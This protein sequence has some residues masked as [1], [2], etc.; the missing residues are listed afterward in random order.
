MFR[1]LIIKDGIVENIINWS[2]DGDY[3]YPFPHDIIMKEPN[4]ISVGIGDVYISE[5]NEFQKPIESYFIGEE[6]ISEE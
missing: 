2:G 5:T 4:G 3:Q 1:Y 6:I